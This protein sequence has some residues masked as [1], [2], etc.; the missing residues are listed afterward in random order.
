MFAALASFGVS[1]LGKENGDWRDAL[2]KG[3]A[4]SLKLFPAFTVRR[5][6]QQFDD[7]V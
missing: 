1:V 7:I 4:E 5:C 2:D 3:Q 6:H